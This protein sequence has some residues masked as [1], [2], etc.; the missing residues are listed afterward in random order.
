MESKPFEVKA[1]EA[2]DSYCKKIIRYAALDCHNS[3]SRQL[4]H[5]ATFSELSVQEAAQLAATDKYF[6]DSHKFDVL[7]ETVSVLSDSLV[8]ALTD[9]PPIYRKIVLVS[10]FFNMTDKEIAELLNM[11]RRTVAYHRAK[12]LSLLKK[13]METEL[14][15]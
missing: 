7:G 11:K 9:L 2:Y 10:F 5:E 15:G 3:R 14:R 13:I 4:K 12:T 6:M 1:A 8:E